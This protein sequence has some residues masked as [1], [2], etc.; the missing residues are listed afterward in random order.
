MVWTKLLSHTTLAAT[1]AGGLLL[2]G[3][4]P[5]AHADDV[6]ACHRNV[7]KWQDRLQHDIDRH[8]PDSKQARHDRHELDEARDSCHKRFG[9]QWR[10][11]DDHH[12]NDSDR[13]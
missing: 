1:L 5:L 8:G 12:D 9:D 3:A 11:N 4:A 13:R 6:A 10:D 2:F 7:D